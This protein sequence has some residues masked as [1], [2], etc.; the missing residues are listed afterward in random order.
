VKLQLKQLSDGADLQS[1]PRLCIGTECNRAEIARIATGQKRH[2]LQ[3]RAS[4]N[5][6]QNDLF[7]LLNSELIQNG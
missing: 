6:N 1:V 7:E 3:I 5:C 2:G 4:R